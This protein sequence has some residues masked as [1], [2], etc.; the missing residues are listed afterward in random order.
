MQN[1]HRK[2]ILYKRL[3]RKNVVVKMATFDEHIKIFDESI[4]INDE[5]FFYDG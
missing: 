2:F 1:E 3:N 4:K 5:G